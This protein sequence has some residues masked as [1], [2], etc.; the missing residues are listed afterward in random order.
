MDNTPKYTF[1]IDKEDE[2]CRVME[3]QGRFFFIKRFPFA[4]SVPQ[5]VQNVPHL[6]QMYQGGELQSHF[7]LRD[8]M[9]TSYGEF[10]VPNFMH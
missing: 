5:H 4:L 2:R 3:R 10:L 7:I 6:G 8:N 1:C 9:G